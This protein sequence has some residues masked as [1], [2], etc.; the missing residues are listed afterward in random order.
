MDEWDRYDVDGNYDPWGKV[1]KDDKVDQFYDSHGMGG[2]VHYD[3]W[4]NPDNDI[5]S[6]FGWH[7]N[8]SSGGNG[9]SSSRRKAA[10]GSGCGCCMVIGIIA[11]IASVA[12]IIFVA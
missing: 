10:A 11:A 2:K 3:P 7:P 4:W 8:G 5:P 12:V 6:P 9:W 1:G